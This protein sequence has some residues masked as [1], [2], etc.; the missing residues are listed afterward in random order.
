MVRSVLV[1]LLLDPAPY[2][3]KLGFVVWSLLDRPLPDPVS[4]EDR[5]ELVGWLALEELLLLVPV[6]N[7]SNKVPNESNSASNDN[8][9]SSP[10]RPPPRLEEGGLKTE[11]DGFEE[12]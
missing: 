9:K 11:P 6:P 8:P 3:D 12:V 7:D 10:P 4:Y 2:E 5:L 1:K